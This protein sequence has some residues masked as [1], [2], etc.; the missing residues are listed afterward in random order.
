MGRGLMPFFSKAIGTL[1]G[2]DSADASS[3][4]MSSAGTLE[5]SFRIV[6]T[7][8]RALD[9]GMRSCGRFGP[10]RLGSTVER[11]SSTVVV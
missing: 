2:K 6:P 4:P 9:S 7:T 8:L 10:A 1:A 5:P 3:S 11:S